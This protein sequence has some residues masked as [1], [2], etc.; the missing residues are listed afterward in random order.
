[1]KSLGEEK[2]NNKKQKQ[3]QKKKKKKLFKRSCKQLLYN[4]RPSNDFKNG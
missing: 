1:M 4:R 3:K 2:K